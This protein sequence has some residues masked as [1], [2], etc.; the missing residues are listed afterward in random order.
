VVSIV[1]TK[2]ARSSVAFA[3]IDV[4]EELL[5][6][7]SMLFTEPIGLPPEHHRSHQIQL[8]LGTL[9]IVVPPYQYMHHQKQQLER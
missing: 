9:P 7:F 5:Q 8:L 4:L 2:P 3:T 6:H 1:I